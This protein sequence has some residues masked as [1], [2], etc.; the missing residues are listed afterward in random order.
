MASPM[1]M[2]FQAAYNLAM[3]CAWCQCT[4]RKISLSLRLLRCQKAKYIASERILEGW[5]L[6]C[7]RKDAGAKAETS[8]VIHAI[9]HAQKGDVALP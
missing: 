3:A 9:E 4:Q 5:L 6:R 2:R 8:S 7:K 1:G